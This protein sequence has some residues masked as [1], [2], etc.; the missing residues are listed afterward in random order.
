MKIRLTTCEDKLKTCKEK[1]TMANDKLKAAEEKMK[2]QG[3]LLDSAQQALSKRELSYS[4]V[5]SS[6]VANTVVLIK[7]HLPDLDMEILHKDFTVDDAPTMPPMSL[8]HCTISPALLSL[9]IIIVPR[10]CNSPSV[11]CNKLL[12]VHKN[13]DLILP[14]T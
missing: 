10:L 13:F 5:I 11:C 3:Q 1:L 6:V 12:L 8:S 14:N 4:A 9:M 2:T 7:N